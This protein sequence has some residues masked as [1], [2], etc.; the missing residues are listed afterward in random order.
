VSD[1]TC[2]G[3]PVLRAEL[4]APLHGRWIADVEVDTSEALT[5]AVEVR[6]GGVAW[7]GTVL[8]GGIDGADVWKGRIVGGAGGLDQPVTARSWLGLQPARGLFVELLTEVGET[9]SP[10]SGAPVDTDLAR[11]SRVDCT[12]HRALADLASVVGARWRLTPEGTVW[13]GLETWPELVLP[14]GVTAE[15][16]SVNPRMASAVYA[17]PG[18]WILPGTVFEGRRVGGVVYRLDGADRA[19]VYFTDEVTGV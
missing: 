11:W 17:L 12:A 2:A 1:W 9:L 3:A 16:L 4:R 10:S 14:E 19:H 18:S 8:R 5:G 6:I 15:P 13:V 7:R